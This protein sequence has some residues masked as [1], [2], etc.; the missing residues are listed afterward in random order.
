MSGMVHVGAIHVG[1][2]AIVMALASVVGC[3]TH[4]RHRRPVETQV[5]ER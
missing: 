2:A 3:R 1:G 5:P 4:Q